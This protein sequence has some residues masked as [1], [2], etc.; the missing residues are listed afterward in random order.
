MTI[1]VEV[2][3]PSHPGFAEENTPKSWDFQSN[4]TQSI[5]PDIIDIRAGGQPLDLKS[6]IRSS[7]QELNSDGL[8]SFPSLLLWDEQGLK[9]FEQITHIPEYYLT[10]AEISLLEAHGHQIACG[11]KPGTILLELGSGCLR[12]VNILLQALEALGKKV[13]Y[14]ALDLDPKELVR[15]L[16]E[17]NPSRFRHVHCHGLLGAYEDG[18][19]WLGRD[20][21]VTRSKCV[22]SLGSTMGS[23]TR[24]DASK[25][26]EKWAKVLRQKGNNMNEQPDAKMIIG[27][28]GCKDEKRVLAAYNDPGGINKEFILNVLKN[29]NSQLEYEALSHE[30][31]SVKG[32]WDADGGKHV[33]YLTPIREISFEGVHLRKGERVLVAYSHKYDDKDKSQLWE[34]S[35][36]KNVISYT[37]NDIPY[38]TFLNI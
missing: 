3:H 5:Y 27:L 35:Q 28:D 30:D 8:R 29:A 22:L 31:W 23:F 34:R 7:F 36:L 24:A 9:Y 37:H 12:K 38:G 32:E 2:L 17:L 20:T 16:Q 25:F 15:A 21:N 6:S 18:M 13:D 4:K 11:I 10:N 26:L 33:Q 19:A 1:D 14:Y